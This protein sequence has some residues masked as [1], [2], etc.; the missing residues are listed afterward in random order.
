MKKSFNPCVSLT[1]LPTLPTGR[2]AVGRL[3][4]FLTGVNDG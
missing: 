2:Q 1:T 4:S 3:E